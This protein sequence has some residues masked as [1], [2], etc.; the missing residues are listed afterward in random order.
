[1][2]KRRKKS[3]IKTKPRLKALKIED[4]KLYKLFLMGYDDLASGYSMIPEEYEKL[5]VDD[6]IAYRTGMIA[7]RVV[8]EKTEGVE[9]VAELQQHNDI[10]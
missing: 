2:G 9:F 3:A 8:L 10:L 7:A 4:T 1:M 6:Q 5:P